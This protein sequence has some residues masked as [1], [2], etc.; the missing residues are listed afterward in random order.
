LI[1]NCALDLGKTINQ[2]PKDSE[3]GRKY[4]RKMILVI[5]TSDY[6]RDALLYEI[7]STKIA[8]AYFF[9]PNSQL[10]LCFDSFFK[11]MLIVTQ[12]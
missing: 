7:I 11:L 9:P 1:S 12:I 2:H 8:D 10:P 4:E 3:R 5:A 6:G